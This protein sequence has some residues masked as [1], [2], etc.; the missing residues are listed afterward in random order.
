M[1]VRRQFYC[2]SLLH[3]EFY[4]LEELLIIGGTYFRFSNNQRVV[5]S[6]QPLGDK[7]ILQF[8]YWLYKDSTNLKCHGQSYLNSLIEVRV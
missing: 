4:S 1:L 6:G 2:D 8:F 5:T 7:T 3:Q